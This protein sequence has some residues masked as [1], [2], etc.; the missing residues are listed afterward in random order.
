MSWFKNYSIKSLFRQPAPRNSATIEGY[1]PYGEHD[2]YPLDWSNVIQNSPTA[3]SCLGTLQDFIE[4]Q[5]FSDDSLMKR[6]VNAKKQTLWQLHQQSSDSWGEFEGFAW[7]IRYNSLAQITEVEFLPF[8]NCRL[9]KP[10][11]TGFISKIHYNP[12]FGTAEYKGI[13]KKQTIVYDVFNPDAVKLQIERDK[14]K[15]K[16]Q[17]Y[18]CATTT[19]LSRYYPRPKPTAAKK[20]MKIE[21]GIADYHEDKIDNGFLN[22][23]ILIMKGDPNEPSNNPDYA[24]TNGEGKPGTVAQ[25]FDDV[26]E[27]NFMGKG[28]HANVMVQWVNNPDEKPEIL[29][30]PSSA[31]GDLFITLDN[32]ATKKITVAWKVPSILANISEGVSLGGDGNQVRVSVKLMQQRVLKEQKILTDAYERILKLMVQPYNDEVKIVSYNPYPELE[33]IDDKVWEAMTPE[34][35]RQWIKDNTNIKLIEET[36]VETPA[37]E[38]ITQPVQNFVNAVPVSFPDNVIATVKRALEY[39][40]KMGIKCGGKAGIDVA[41]SIV[42]NQN[43]GLKQLKRIHNYLKKNERFSNSPFNEG[44]DVILYNR[45]GGKPMFD[46]LEVKLKDLEQWLNKTN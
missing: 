9:G 21:A 41:N 7:L 29:S 16:G 11:D 42:A 26:M 13:D 38:P 31:N 22:D 35:K 45:W 23:Y 12:F 37:I 30:V 10:D 43:M 44:C 40:D 6:P 34:E 1:L 20:W 18:Y 39:G 46:F 28:Q 33:I 32:Q 24:N 5:K 25:E 19:S 8:E 2:N 15:Y 27:K 36:V 4:G 3:N 14:N 17:V